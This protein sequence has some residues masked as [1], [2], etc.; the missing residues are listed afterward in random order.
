MKTILVDAVGTFVIE[1]NGVYKP[2]F[3]L[4]E[5]YPNRKIILTNANDEQL[6]PF[7]LTNL[8]YEMFTLKHNPDKVDTVYFQKMLQHYGLT[9]EDVIYFEHS[10]EAVKSAESLG[11]KSYHYDSLKQDLQ[12][13]KAF[14]DENVKSESLKLAEKYLGKEVE[15][16][17]D[18]PLGSLHPKHGFKY[19]ANY[20]YI[21]GVKAPDGE[22]LDAY[23][24]GTDIPLQIAKGKVIAIVHR[25]NDDDDKLIVVPENTE[26]TDEDIE[27]ATQFQ[28]QWFEHKIIR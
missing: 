5:K 13:L 24:L 26:L 25:L 6:I 17:I 19:G 2:M 21:K 14:L 22:D 9:V 3:E 28:E 27:K 12:A 8:P 1:G 18:R 11:I 4:L 7:S 16:V 20:G 15:I 23:F 10:L